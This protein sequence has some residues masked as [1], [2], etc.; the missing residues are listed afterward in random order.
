[1]CSSDL[2]HWLS[3][4]DL[5]PEVQLTCARGIVT[6]SARR[7]WFVIEPSVEEAREAFEARRVLELGMLRNLKSLSPAAL[8]QLSEHVSQEKAALGGEDVSTRSF[9]LGDFHVCLADALG[10]R[11]LSN[12]LRDYTARTTLIAML[13]QSSHQAEQSCTEHQLIVQELAKG[14]FAR[15]EA[16][17][18]EHLSSVESGL[19]QSVDN[20]PLSSLRSALAPIAK[21]CD[22]APKLTRPRAKRGDD[23]PAPEDDY[24]GK[25]L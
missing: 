6:V 9:L 23:S 19:R 10:N 12:T 8:Q 25:L 21:R 20:D 3:R 5:K 13:Y 22:H 18:A 17:M 16:L 7:G 15:A 2:D 1:M 14:D 4:P 24:L 11:L